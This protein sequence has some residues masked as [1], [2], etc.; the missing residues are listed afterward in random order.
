MS[1]IK[2]IA[3]YGS[4]I[5]KDPFTTV[6][7]E[8][9]K[10]YY[11]CI[12][13][14]QRHSFIST[15]QEKED[16]SDEELI[17]LPEKRS[18]RFL[19]K[20]IKEDLKKTFINAILENDIDYIVFDIHFE[21]EQGIMIYDENKILTN[22]KG[23]EKTEYFSKLKNVRYL[24]I[25]ENT[26]TYLKLWKKYCD[27]FFN[28]IK[29]NSP[30]TKIILAEVRALDIVQRED[31]SRYIEPTFNYK[32]KINNIYYKVLEDYIKENYDVEVVS[33]HKD[34]VLKENHLWGKFYLHYDDEYYTNFLKKIDKIV[35][36]ND[37]EKKLNQAMTILNKLELDI[38]EDIRIAF[39]DKGI[40]ANNNENWVDTTPLPM[41]RTVTEKYTSLTSVNPD[42]RGVLR[43]LCNIYDGTII[44]FDIY[45]D[46]N[47]IDE[48]FGT[49]RMDTKVYANLRFTS[50]NLKMKEWHHIKLSISNDI[51]TM[52]NETNNKTKKW[53][54]TKYN[55]FY[56]GVTK[57]TIDLKY[58]NFK[59]IYS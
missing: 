37:L 57:D 11:N 40:I 8:N 58:K 18:N 22:I 9:Y 2:N 32:T 46:S 4:C 28:F 31:S 3:I 16:V 52:S 41:K 53:R 27:K 13:N 36:H 14:D 29:K 49:I 47:N 5:T 7:N 56:F 54:L 26:D 48:V 45:H 21:V 25:I 34:T 50:M 17:I 43:P 10:H 19:T 59:I 33:F 42:G 23:I 30:E 55:R 1:R 44:E 24:N 12:V 38:D 6:F 35:Q 51:L 39:Y 20:C 15:M